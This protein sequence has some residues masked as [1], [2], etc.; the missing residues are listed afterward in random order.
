MGRVVSDIQPWLWLGLIVKVFLVGF[1]S[2]LSSNRIMIV[3][4]IVQQKGCWSLSACPL[5]KRP[6]WFS[7]FRGE[8]LNA[9]IIPFIPDLKHQK[10]IHAMGMLQNQGPPNY[11]K[12]SSYPQKRS[13]NSTNCLWGE[14]WDSAGYLLYIFIYH[15]YTKQSYFAT[16]L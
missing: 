5:K 7:G 1:F 8:D 6:L 3:T 2:S 15:I 16:S 4:W 10:I 13:N 9:A 14:A 12:N 11:L